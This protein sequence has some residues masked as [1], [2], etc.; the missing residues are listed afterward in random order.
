MNVRRAT[1]DVLRAAC[2][3]MLLVAAVHAQ[4]VEAPALRFERPVTVVASGPQRLAIDLPLLASGQPFGVAGSRGR[5]VATGGLGD[6]RFYD[7]S[8]SEVQY[9]LVYAPPGEP[10]WRRG[11]VLPVAATEKT[12]GFEADLGEPLTIDMVRVEGLPAPFLKRLVLEG[13]GDRQRWT[14]LVAEG[15]LFDL[16]NEQLRQTDLPFARGTYRYLRV[17]WNDANSGRV[18]L[19][20]FV[21]ARRVAASAPPPPLTAAVEIERRPSE[22]GRSR[23]RIRLPGARLPIVAF[24]LHADGGH[25]FREA[26]VFQSRLAGSQAVPAEVG[27][28]QLRRVVR[29]GIAAGSLRIPVAGIVEAELDLVIEDGTNVPLPVTGATAVFAELPWIYLET[30]ASALNARYGNSLVRSPTYDL[31]AVRDRVTIT[32][33]PEAKWGL[34]RGITTTATAAAVAPLPSAGAPLEGSA[35]R[36]VRALPAGDAQLVALVLDAPVLAQSKGP[37]AAFADVRVLDAENRQVPYLVQRR[38]EPMPI[39]LKIAPA[40]GE[41]AALQRAEGGTWSSYTIELPYENLPDA[42]LVIETSARV[43]RRN[44]RLSLERAADRQRRDRWLQV[45]ASEPWMHAN[46]EDPAPALTLRVPRLQTRTVV[47]SIDEGDNQ[48]LP[49]LAA[50]LLLPSYRLRFFRAAGTELRLAYGRDDLAPPRYDLALLA[51]HVM[52]V[53]AR[54]IAAAPETQPSS[55]RP[56]SIVSPRFF[57]ILLAVAVVA[58]LAL[59]VRLA[60]RGGDVT[61]ERSEGR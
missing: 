50:R 18:P 57:W 30:T 48:P 32:G 7:A 1:C 3:A 11:T 40:P 19:P 41:I 2:Y 14:V 21:A 53:D 42:R 45:L 51:P 28:A 36:H 6:L 23:Y 47:L 58:L 49:L 4:S 33:L 31:E 35:F 38:D 10:E 52:G 16:P 15:T 37:D 54:E 60:V 5:P 26:A 20:P 61:G 34:P 59:I 9:I 43:F 27:R 29:D 44:V 24:E 22:P 17:T 25:V 56:T 39:D 55:D 8:G 12:S 46:Q 13:S